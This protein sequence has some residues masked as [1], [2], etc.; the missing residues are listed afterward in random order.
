MRKLVAVLGA[1]AAVAVVWTLGFVYWHLRMERSIETFKRRWQTVWMDPE[2]DAALPR[3]CGSRVILRIFRELELETKK[4][5]SNDRLVLAWEY[6]L[7]Y[8][9]AT[10][11]EG[12]PE[13][14]GQPLS[15]R[16]Y[17]KQFILDSGS[18]HYHLRSWWNRNQPDFPPAWQWWTGR[19][20]R[21][22]EP[23]LDP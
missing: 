8:A 6:E 2:P 21:P 5:P 18:M 19:R 13:L 7:G 11:E 16:A 23:G 4:R 9:V 1:I 14:E 10:A 20:R 12:I 22:P 15:A 17:P 3:S